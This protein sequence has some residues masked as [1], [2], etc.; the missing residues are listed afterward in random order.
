MSDQ[1]FAV[2]A[3]CTANI[4]RSPII[5]ITL[6]AGLD[7]DRFEVASA[8]VNGFIN[9]PMDAMSEMELLRLGL[10]AGDFRSHRINEYLISA[11]DLILTATVDHRHRTL[12]VEPRAMRSSFTLREFAALCPLLDDDDLTLSQLVAAAASRRQELKG[13]LDISDPYRRSPQVHRET[14]DQIA[15]ATQTVAERLTRC[16]I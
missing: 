10:S 8:G 1:R 14:A 9:E 16:P 15:E 6:R 4:C 13:S 2:L 12:E 5:E 11:A 7:P 3:V